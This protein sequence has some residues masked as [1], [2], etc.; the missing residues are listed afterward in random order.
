MTFGDY[1][2]REDIT[3]LIIDAIVVK[4]SPRTLDVRH[5][6]TYLK[7]AIPE[8]WFILPI[9]DQESAFRAYSVLASDGTSHI[10]ISLSS[11]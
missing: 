9:G 10:C 6:Y 1:V 4:I 8:D 11:K 7:R 2:D 3:F 5:L